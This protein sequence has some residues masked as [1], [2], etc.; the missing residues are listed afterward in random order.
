MFF[1]YLT[2]YCYKIYINLSS[3]CQYDNNYDIRILSNGIVLFNRELP[4][5]NEFI[6]TH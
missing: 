2:Q 5:D 6:L 3:C 1:N 4:Y